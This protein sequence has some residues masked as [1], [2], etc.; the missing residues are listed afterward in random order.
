M[1]IVITGAA[2][3]I[4]SILKK[5]L[6]KSFDHELVLIDRKNHGDPAIRITDLASN[7]TAWDELFAGADVVIHL[8]GDPCP[9]APWKVLAINNIDATLNV[10]RAAAE[11]NVRRV[12]YASTLTTME[13]YRYSTKPISADRTP[14]PVTFYAVSKLMGEVIGRSFAE[15]HGMSVICLRL[16]AVQSEPR[17]PARSWTLWSRARWLSGEDLCQAIE[18]AIL[19]ED[20]AFAVLPVIS[21]NEARTWELSETCTALGYRPAKGTTADP[22]RFLTRIRAFLGWVHRRYLDPRWQHYWH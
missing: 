7:Y 12:I 16:G 5:H 3:R 6:A 14:R 4:G 10:F 13:G 1:R 8:A 20:I 15:R 19:V 9:E 22:P 17:T 11:H 18:K 21:D 2:G